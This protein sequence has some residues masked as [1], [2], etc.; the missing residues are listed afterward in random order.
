MLPSSSTVGCFVQDSVRVTVFPGATLL[1]GSGC[2]DP[3]VVLEEVVSCC[4]ATTVVAACSALLLSTSN[5]V[6]P[7]VP[8]IAAALETVG[9]PPAEAMSTQS[10]PSAVVVVVP[11]PEDCWPIDVS[12][13][14]AAFLS[15]ARHKSMASCTH[16]LQSR[17]VCVVPFPAGP[18][19]LL[20]IFFTSRTK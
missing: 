6:V 3:D 8:L 13:S 4:C 12:V 17:S 11:E 18:S 1:F 15:L 10:W 19:V 20:T 14:A 5:H 2:T 9:R 7:A 16:Q